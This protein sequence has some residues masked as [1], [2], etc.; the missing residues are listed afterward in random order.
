[1][2]RTIDKKCPTTGLVSKI[3]IIA[4]NNLPL[5]NPCATYK[6]RNVAIN[7]LAIPSVGA[8][9]AAYRRVKTPENLIIP[10][11]LEKIKNAPINKNNIMSIYVINK[12]N[13]IYN[14]YAI[15]QI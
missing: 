4:S 13:Y 11:A 12:I 8:L 9:V 7:I 5:N 1:L 6:K 14:I 10:I 3:N 2:F 15:Y